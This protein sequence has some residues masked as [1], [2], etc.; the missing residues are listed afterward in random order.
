ME[1]VFFY[2]CSFRHWFES[3]VPVAAYFRQFVDLSSPALPCFGWLA[4]ERWCRAS[5]SPWLVISLTQFG[6]CCQHWQ[7]CPRAEFLRLLE[8]CFSDICKRSTVN[9]FVFIECYCL[10][11]LIKEN[12]TKKGKTEELKGKKYA[13]AE[14][15]RI[16]CMLPLFQIKFLSRM[17]HVDV[18]HMWS[19]IHRQW[20]RTLTKLWL[21]FQTAFVFIFLSNTF[22]AVVQ[23]CR[24]A[25]QGLDSLQ[26]ILS[27]AERRATKISQ[28]KWNHK[29]KS[30]T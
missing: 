1:Q 14:S 12:C 11:E 2:F 28:I 25:W 18:I 19:F 26:C 20:T 30:T 10:L 9:Y 7:E 3:L 8:R 24:Q 5:R 4:L 17:W 21:R 6:H 15:L 23:W 29:T 22:A 16:V 13:P 27:A